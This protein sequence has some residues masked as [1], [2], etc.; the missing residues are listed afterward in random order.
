MKK[1]FLKSI[2]LILSV[3][4]CIVL[5]NSCMTGMLIVSCMQ[6]Y[7]SPCCPPPPPEEDFPKTYEN[8]I[9]EYSFQKA[10]D[11]PLLELDFYF[12]NDK[13]SKHPKL[14]IV[15]GKDIVEELSTK[16]ID[17]TN[18]VSFVLKIISKNKD[19]EEIFKNCIM[20]IDNDS[21]VL[22]NYAKHKHKENI[23]MYGTLPKNI[24]LKISNSKKFFLEFKIKNKKYKYDLKIPSID[25]KIK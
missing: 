21:Y 6:S 16:N 5:L 9:T 11:E 20:R 23:F 8:W 1:C 22:Y 10:D 14:R 19:E 18:N 15:L 4:A 25:D 3:I 17:Y 12:L 13:L 7:Y 2:A 24:F